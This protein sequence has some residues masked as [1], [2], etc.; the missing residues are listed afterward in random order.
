MYSYSTSCAYKLCN[1]L[2]IC[3]IVE[4]CVLLGSLRCIVR[5]KR[6]KRHHI[7]NNNNEIY[8][9]TECLLGGRKCDHNLLRTQLTANQIM[10]Y[11]SRNR[12]CTAVRSR[13]IIHETTNTQKSVCEA[14]PAQYQ[15]SSC[16][17]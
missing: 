6:A 4:Y 10:Y 3:N 1:H 5:E 16:F 15:T 17:I 7:N 12:E 11:M 14:Y 8:Q 2:A 9:V 13:V